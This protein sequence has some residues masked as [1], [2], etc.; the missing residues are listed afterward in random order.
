M[1]NPNFDQGFNNLGIIFE[2]TNQFN[3][4]INNFNL[5][6]K[7]NPNFIQVYINLSKV[8]EKTNKLDMV[9]LCYDK[10]LKFNKNLI[11]LGGIS[12]HNLNS[13]NNINCQGF[14]LLSEIKKKP[15]KIFSRLF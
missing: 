11:P 1:I 14:A 12:I 3:N 2:E 4:A 6:L 9:I 10:Y 13:L 8:Y 7:L 15:A 5:A